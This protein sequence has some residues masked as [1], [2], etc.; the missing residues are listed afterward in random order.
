LN[1]RAPGHAIF[2]RFCIERRDSTGPVRSSEVV[3]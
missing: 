1:E 2:L 3:R